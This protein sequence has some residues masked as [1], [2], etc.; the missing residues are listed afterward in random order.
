MARH[1]RFRHRL[2]KHELIEVA[3]PLHWLVVC[4]EQALQ[5]LPVIQGMERHVAVRDTGLPHGGVD[6]RGLIRCVSWT[7]AESLDTSACR[8]VLPSQQPDERRA[9][10]AA[11]ER[12]GHS[13]RG[14]GSR[15]H[16]LAS[17]ARISSFAGVGLDTLSA[18]AT[19]GSGN[20]EASRRPNW[21]STEARSQE[22]CS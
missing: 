15:Q 11:A 13:R 18:V 17:A 1:P 22:M 4:T 8:G 2:A 9:V 6:Q 7:D 5:S 20:A 10:D 19:P 12:N 14:S 3:D 16:R 21:T